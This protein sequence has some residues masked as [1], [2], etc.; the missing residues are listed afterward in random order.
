MYT[1]RS[2][3]LFMPDGRPFVVRGISW[4]GA[5]TETFCPHGLWAANMEGIVDAMVRCGFNA[6]RL[7]F[8]VEFV[9]QWDGTPNGIDFTK[10]PKLKGL[11]SAQ[12]FDAVIRKCAAS[13][14]LV[15][16][17]MHRLNIKEI[18]ELWYDDQ[19]TEKDVLDAWR[20]MARRCAGY[21][22]VFAFDLRNE[23][24]G[25]RVQWGSGGAAFDFKA[26]TERMAEAVLAVNP[27]PLIFVEGL[28]RTLDALPGVGC[29]WG[30]NLDHIRRQPVALSVPN[31]VVYSPHTYGFD[32][33]DMPQFHTP[34]F[35]RNLRDIWEAKYGCITRAPHNHTVVVGEFGSKYVAGSIDETIQDR[36]VDYIANDI[37]CSA[38][39]WCLNNNGA[40]TAGLFAADWCTVNARYATL[41]AKAVPRPTKFGAM[42]TNAPLPQPQVVVPVKPPAPASQPIVPPVKPTPTVPSTGVP[43]VVSAVSSWTS[44]ADTM[45]QYDVTIRNPFSINVREA[46]VTVDVPATDIVQMWSMTAVPNGGGT[47]LGLPLWISTYGWAAGATHLFGIIVRNRPQG[48]RVS[49]VRATPQ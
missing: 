15:M 33:H 9:K 16:P 11:T 30:E 13:G 47:V 44:G 7:P 23:V 42:S 20:R 14:V 27:R 49:A 12:V 1:T 35:P 25:P 32:V 46:Y 36:L 5:E 37:K 34:D 19:Y 40:D 48:M 8:S 2:N 21:E 18:S 38:F 29:Y 31:K 39:L 3:A 22:N 43:P 10:N 4:F 45:T 24:H 28:D 41:A 17:V 26:A 6:V